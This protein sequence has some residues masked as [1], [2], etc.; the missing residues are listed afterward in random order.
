MATEQDLNLA[1][2]LAKEAEAIHG[3]QWE[4]RF[5]RLSHFGM[6]KV[7]LTPTGKVAGMTDFARKILAHAERK[8][9]RR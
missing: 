5:E 7:C 1:V 6:A 4:R 3:L 9:A 2:K 8:R